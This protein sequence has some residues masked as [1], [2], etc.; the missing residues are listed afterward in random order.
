MIPSSGPSSTARS[1]CDG[2][3]TEADA[4]Y[5]VTVVTDTPDDTE[6][7]GTAVTG[8]TLETIGEAVAGVGAV[9]V[10]SMGEYDERGV[11]A[12]VPYVGL[13][14]S[15]PRREA[16]VAT[17]TEELGRSVAS[18]AD[19]VTTPAGVDI[20]AKT[21]AEIAVSVL[22]ELIAVRRVDDGPGPG[23]AGEVEVT[24]T[25]EGQEDMTYE[26]PV[27]GMSVTAAEAARTA[28]RDGETWYFCSEAY[29]AAFS[30]DAEERGP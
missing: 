24:P 12:S 5:A 21:P 26:D 9:V 19:A 6:S 18:V 1:S 16:V 11:A 7:R 17:A 30:A 25:T 29:A 10:A 2:E 14:A 15:E 20:G 28:T 22:A 8:R 27:C 23:A 13:V 3:R 4:G